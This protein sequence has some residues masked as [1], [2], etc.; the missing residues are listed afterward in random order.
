MN[1]YKK[2]TFVTVSSFYKQF[3]VVFNE[4]FYNLTILQ[5]FKTMNQS[6]L[7]T[8][9]KVLGLLLML[10]ITLASQVNAQNL[11]GI[12]SGIQ[13]GNIL[14]CFNWKISDVKAEL[15]NIAAAGFGSVQLSPLQR[16]SAVGSTWADIYRPYDFKFIAS[17]LGTKEDLTSLCAEAEKY[18]I[19]IIVDVV[20]NHVDGHGAGD[21]SLYHDPWWNSN[22]RLRWN[23]DVNYGNRNSITHNQIGGGS[24]YPDVN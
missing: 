1:Q 12:P 23:G 17:G 7:R 3:Y 22:N 2:H 14:H 4:Q 15:P 10:A 24:G 18:G 13:E 5:M 20:A 11:Y 16:N 9:K 8:S 6:L 19:K 21:H